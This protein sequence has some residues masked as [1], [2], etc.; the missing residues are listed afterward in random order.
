MRLN[1]REIQDKPGS[2]LAF[3]CELDTERLEFPAV[4]KYLVPPHAEGVVKNAAGALSLS[5]KITAELV[6]I[7]DRCAMQF[8]LRREVPLEVKLTE[9]PQDPE[10]PELFPIE[11]SELDLDE[12][13]ETCFILDMDSKF[14]CRPDCAGLCPGCGANLN[15]GECTCRQTYD[16]RLAVLEQLLDNES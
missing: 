9:D 10:D 8:E 3:S 15:D 13:L 1:L 11:D 12:L 2:Q 7:C 16:P 5:G 6:C 14:L 4:E